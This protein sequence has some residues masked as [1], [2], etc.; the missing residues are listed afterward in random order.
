MNN[1]S[2]EQGKE[3]CDKC[4]IELIPARAFSDGEPTYVGY[5][6]HECRTWN[7]ELGHWEPYA[8]ATTQPEQSAR[9]GGL[10]DNPYVKGTLPHQYWDEGYYKC[11]NDAKTWQASQSSVS[12]EEGWIRV[13]DK[14]PEED[15]NVFVWWK[16]RLRIMAY[17]YIDAG[18]GEDSGWAW[19]DCGTDIE[20]DPEFDDEYHPSHWMP[21]PEKPL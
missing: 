20:G 8:K 3:Y 1:Q 19:C 16:G 6:P 7:E 4:G 12:K 18:I 14:K 9:E 17:Q 15:V 2:P 5:L 13:E 21:L 10:D 11:L